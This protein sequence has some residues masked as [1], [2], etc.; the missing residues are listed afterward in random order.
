MERKKLLGLILAAIGTASLTIFVFSR[1]WSQKK[2]TIQLNAYP[3]AIVYIDGREAGTTPYR[4][5]KIKAGESHFRLVPEASFS[6]V[7]ERKLILTPNTET[8]VNWE[9][10]PDPEKEAGSILYL[11][12]TSLKDKAGLI[13]T[14]HPDSCSVTVDGQMR[15]FAPLNLEDVGEGSHQIV[16][17]LPGYKGREIMAKVAKGYRLVVE[18]KLAKES[19]MT[20]KQEEPIEETS[21]EEEPSQTQVLIKETPTGW[22]RVRTGPSTAATEAAKV[23]PGE[24]YPFLEEK[25]G[26]Y[27]IEYQEGKE[28]W[29]SGR[30]AQKLD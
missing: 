12:K 20:T 10:S 14:C 22:L 28:G 11:E 13:V 19:E 4:N 27:K 2:A 24:K 21:D 17:A 8:V 18:V 6:A 3:K 30:Y 23:K 25:N 26:W 16:V 7:W 15:G 29:V 9:F 1:G 5:D